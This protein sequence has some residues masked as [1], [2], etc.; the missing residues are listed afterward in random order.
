MFSAIIEKEMKKNK[1]LLKKYYQ[2]HKFCPD[3]GTQNYKS[4][5]LGYVFNNL[6]DFRDNNKVECKCGWIGTFHELTK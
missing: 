1:K 5:R 6:K 2:K 4:N 3:C